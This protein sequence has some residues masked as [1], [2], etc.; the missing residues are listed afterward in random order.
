MRKINSGA[1]RAMINVNA[2]IIIMLILCI[3]RHHLIEVIGL[4]TRLLLPS[5]VLATLFA[6]LIPRMSMMTITVYMFLV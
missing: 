6:S 2:V 1:C 4:E 3:H 5:V